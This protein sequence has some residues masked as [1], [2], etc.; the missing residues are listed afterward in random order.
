[1]TT[2]EG[3]SGKN[4]AVHARVLTAIKGDG[5]PNGTQFT[6]VDPAD[7]KV[8]TETVTQ[9]VKKFEQVAKDDMGVGAE[10]RPQVVHY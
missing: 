7:G 1:V 6:I 9:F 3:S 10:L 4:F 8:H 2:D 5:T